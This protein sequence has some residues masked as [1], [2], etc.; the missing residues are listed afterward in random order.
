LG[1]EGGISGKEEV[2][3]RVGRRLLFVR[4]SWQERGANVGLGDSDGDSDG[5]ELL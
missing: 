5:D 2:G 4:N 3:W 1:I